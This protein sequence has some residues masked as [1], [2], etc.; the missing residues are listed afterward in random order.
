MADPELPIV[1]TDAPDDPEKIQLLGE[2]LDYDTEQYQGTHRGPG[3]RRLRNGIPKLRSE[4]K[5]WG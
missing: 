3:T 1:L 2:P 4:H 5:E